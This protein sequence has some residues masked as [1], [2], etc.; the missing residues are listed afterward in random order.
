V[1]N[2][3]ISDE[4]V[5]TS[6]KEHLTDLE[7]NFERYFR[8]FDEAEH[9]QKLCILNPFDDNAIEQAGI[10][11]EIKEQLFELSADSVLKMQGIGPHDVPEFWKKIKARY[12]QLSNMARTELL[13]LA[14]AYLCEASYSAMKLLKTKL[15]NRMSPENELIVALSSVK[16]RFE[17]LISSK[18]ARISY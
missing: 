16:P 6:L 12:K 14:S 9:R 15:I 5:K 13:P 3:I 11:E 10:S 7:L 1:E 8:S 18:Q 2:E 4:H 17:N